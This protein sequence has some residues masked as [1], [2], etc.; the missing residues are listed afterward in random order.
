V[1]LDGKPAGAAVLQESVTSAILRAAFAEMAE[2]GYARMSMDAV[3]RRAGVGKA[4]IYRRWSSKQEMVVALTA[5]IGVPLADTAD[6][7]SLPATPSQSSSSCSM[8]ANTSRGGAAAAKCQ[9]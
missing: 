3:A 7:G 9:R 4:A 8:T 1:F 6:T 5:Q 2:S